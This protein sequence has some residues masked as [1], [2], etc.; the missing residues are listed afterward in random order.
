VNT[1]ITKCVGVHK[2]A[3]STI[4]RSIHTSRRHLGV[5][6]IAKMETVMS[7]VRTLDI[8]SGDPDFPDLPLINIASIIGGRSRDYDLAGPSNLADYCTIIIDVRYGGDWTSNQIDDLFVEMLESIRLE[9][10]SFQYEYHHPPP[11]RF[12]VG[13]ADMPPTNV[14]SDTEIVAIVERCHSRI[15][16][17]AIEQKGVV[18][19]YSYCGNDTAH[20]E[21][22][23]IPCCLYGPR[24]YDDDVEMHVRIDEMHICASALAACAIEVCK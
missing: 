7:K 8:P 15:T 18:L 1:I 2:C 11:K 24:G 23:G 19:P 17:R 6:A 12:N 9:D 20:L 3:I 5:D 21:K 14:P 13:G 4:G 22:A 16:G 10:T